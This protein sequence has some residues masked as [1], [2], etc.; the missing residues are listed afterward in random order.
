MEHG[1]YLIYQSSNRLFT[2]S[3]TMDVIIK[4]LYNNHN[5]HCEIQNNICFRCH[6]KRNFCVNEIKITR[7]HPGFSDAMDL[8]R[9]TAGVR[10]SFRWYVRIWYQQ[11]NV[12]VRYLTRQEYLCCCVNSSNRWTTEDRGRNR[13]L[14]LAVQCK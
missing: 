3:F 13:T 14:D 6:N 9:T 8:P 1:I 2:N 11:Y 5:P 7:S 10:A 4:Y 12:Y